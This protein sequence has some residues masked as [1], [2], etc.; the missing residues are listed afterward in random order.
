MNKGKKTI[1]LL[2][3]VVVMLP[4]LFTIAPIASADLG[5]TV[6]VSTDGNDT[7]GDGSEQ[8]PFA[9][10]S[11]AWNALKAAKE[12]GK[13]KEG[14]TTVYLRGGRYEITESILL[15]EGVSDEAHQIEFAAYGDETV[16]LSGG[17]TIDYSAF[18]PV[19]GD[20]MVSRFPAAVRNQI[21]VCDLAA[22]G[23]TGY[24]NANSG[25]DGV[26]EL[27]V[28]NVLLTRGR[29]P[30]ESHGYLR[31]EESET[32]EKIK[33]QL[34]FDDGG[35]LAALADI[36]T[37][38]I[39]G[40][41]HVDYFDGDTRV[42]GREGNI[43]SVKSSDMGANC[44]FYYYDAPEFVDTP[45]EYYIDAA[46][47]KLYVCPTE[48]FSTAAITIS[49]LSDPIISVDGADYLTF[50]GMTFTSTLNDGI[51]LYGDHIHFTDNHVNAIGGVAIR[52]NGVGNLIEKNTIEYIGGAGIDF[53]GGSFKEGIPADSMVYNNKILYYARHGHTYNAGVC[54]DEGSY[55]LVVRNNEIGYSIHN[56]VVG[57]C[58]EGLVEYNYIHDV[59]S[60]AHDAGAIYTGGWHCMN[61]T[62][63]YNYITRTQNLYFFGIPSG[64][65]VDDGGSNKRIYGNIVEDTDGFAILIGGGHNNIM[66]NNL[67]IRTRFSP[68]SYDERQNFGR[69]QYP[70][71]TFPG[72]GLLDNP[73]TSTE[74]FVMMYMPFSYMRYTNEY[75]NMNRFAHGQVGLARYRGNIK[76][77]APD[78]EGKFNDDKVLD[79]TKKFLIEADNPLYSVTDDL[80]MTSD[81]QFPS[82]SPIY[83]EIPYWENIDMSRIGTQG[84]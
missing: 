47:G 45:G 10:L 18:A 23:V 24:E 44:N 25:K 54:F 55:Q 30:N 75:D 17:K 19:A 52:V 40:Y 13:L 84:W 34:R 11:A 48:N 63:R 65:Y 60:E 3:A 31:F 77:Q 82:D 64:I 57:G 76:I 15:G 41:L 26:P 38:R 5:D 73:A 22:L 68:L 61:Y 69:D 1:S 12:D 39:H 8:A 71:T 74:E 58:Y 51:Y 56:A 79:M 33:D 9:S 35:I 46:T 37:V 21:L 36:S 29:Y 27:S 28:D 43:V 83:N 16:I 32:A 59:C 78:D 2:C 62:I 49:Q 67:M 20:A 66:Y 7:T 42:L 80:K 81:Y 72:W 14:L 70:R 53:R 6:F 50:R 4:C